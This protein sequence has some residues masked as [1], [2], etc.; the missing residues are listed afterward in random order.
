[1][2]VDESG[3][4]GFSENKHY[5]VGSTPTQFYIRC[6]IILH[7]RKWK[8]ANEAIDGWKY[9]RKIPKQVELHATE[10]LNGKEKYYN[11]DGKRKS[12]PNW[13]GKNFPNR[14][15]RI[16][17]L[18]S[19]CETVS[20]LPLTA[21]A[22]MIDKSKIKRT[23]TNFKNLP[24]ERSWEFLIERYNLFLKNAP[25]KKVSLFQML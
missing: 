5:T 2:Y 6:G 15:K 1:M 23:H 11:R 21:I 20:K 4:D 24:K 25:I 8:R 14:K 22:I 3:D 12:R 10:I 13:Y 19:L 16:E 7:D 18:K 9:S 17:I